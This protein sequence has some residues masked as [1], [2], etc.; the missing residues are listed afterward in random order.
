[1]ADGPSIDIGA[2]NFARGVGQQKQA[3]GSDGTNEKSTVDALFDAPGKPLGYNLP[4][5]MGVPLNLSEAGQ[6]GLQKAFGG[7]TEGL[8]GKTI[9]PSLLHDIGG[10][11]L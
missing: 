3:G 5:M 11:F 2:Q 4:S 6:H 7:D 9:M 8:T 10:G 1:M